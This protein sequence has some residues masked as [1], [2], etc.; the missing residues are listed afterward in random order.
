M[1]VDLIKALEKNQAKVLDE[2]KKGKEATQNQNENKT[3]GET[4]KENK[5][6]TSAF[7]GIK[8]EE[9]QTQQPGDT[10]LNEAKENAAIQNELYPEFK[11]INIEGGNGTDPFADFANDLA[12]KRVQ[13]ENAPV[14]DYSKTFL[15]ENIT[16]FA[17]KVSKDDVKAYVER[18]LKVPGELYYQEYTTTTFVKELASVDV[19]QSLHTYFPSTLSMLNAGV[20]VKSLLLFKTNIADIT[21]Q[22]GLVGHPSNYVEES[23]ANSPETAFKIENADKVFG[24]NNTK[25]FLVDGNTK[26]VL[27]YTNTLCIILGTLGITPEML[28]KTKRGVSVGEKGNFYHVYFIQK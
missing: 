25:C 16:H 4:V 3:G 12:A 5:Q 2:E 1:N 7:A 19:S 21:Q 9:N 10:L 14:I 26:K 17:V 18:T 20:G 22:T 8:K 24:G 13:E 28:R 11:D 6:E 15:D 23:I 27:F